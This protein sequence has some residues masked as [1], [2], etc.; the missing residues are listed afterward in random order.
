MPS[1][2]KNEA[3]SFSFFFFERDINGS[4][5]YSFW[6]VVRKV[7]SSVSHPQLILT[8]GEKVT[9]QQTLAL[10]RSSAS[11]LSPLSLCWW[12]SSW[13]VSSHQGPTLRGLKMCQWWV[14]NHQVFKIVNFIAFV[15]LIC[16][17]LNFK[18]LT[19]CVHRITLVSLDEID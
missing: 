9:W 8:S 14:R 10:W 5:G 19:N 11:S 4:F 2:G 13:N 3:A 15:K 17:H 6:W 16:N 12:L 1:T 18:S 7:T